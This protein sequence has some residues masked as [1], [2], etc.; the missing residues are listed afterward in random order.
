MYLRNYKPVTKS[1]D[2]VSKR[3]KLKFT[4]NTALGQHEPMTPGPNTRKANVTL[5]VRSFYIRCKTIEF[6]I[7]LTVLTL[8]LAWLFPWMNSGKN[9]VDPSE[10]VYE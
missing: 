9:L 7:D 3:Y 4:C 6:L 5:I 1:K 8:N 2:C 10:L